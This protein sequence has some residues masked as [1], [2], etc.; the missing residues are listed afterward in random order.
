MKAWKIVLILLVLVA[1]FALM[2]EL[3]RLMIVE[4]EVPLTI[5]TIK[6]KVFNKLSPG[7]V[8]AGADVYYKVT[9]DGTPAWVWAGATD[10]KGVVEIEG[11]Y[12]SGDTVTLKIVNGTMVYITSFTLPYGTVRG[13]TVTYPK[14]YS[15]TYETYT[16]EVAVVPFPDSLNIIVL[17]PDDSKITNSTGEYNVTTEGVTKPAFTLI[18]DNPT[19]NTGI[20]HGGAD[21]VTGRDYYAVILVRITVTSGS[22][23][24]NIISSGW[25]VLYAP[26]KGDQWFAYTLSEKDLTALDKYVTTTGEESKGRLTK[27]IQFDVLLSSGS[28][29]KVQ[30]W[31]YVN[32][33]KDYF[34]EEHTANSEAESLVY[35]EWLFKA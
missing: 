34:K 2:P 12:A 15:P 28:T 5:S 6:L 24:V 29:A 16:V 8:L 1:A 30:V 19:D 21:P 17:D 33:D 22:G 7:D 35:F 23:S 20:R 26:S 10:S 18:L 25:E 9:V 4:E 3:Q 14:G 11:R 31:F 13:G 32:F 27:Q